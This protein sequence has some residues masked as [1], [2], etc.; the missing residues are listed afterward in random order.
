MPDYNQGRST[1][2]DTKKQNAPQMDRERLPSRRRASRDP[3]EHLNRL[4][5]R[6]GLVSLSAN[7]R[8]AVICAVVIVGLVSIVSV[9]LRI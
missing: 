3:G 7:G 4:S 6:L 2:L 1:M 9:A 5:V 8:I